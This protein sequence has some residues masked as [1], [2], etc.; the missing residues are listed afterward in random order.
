VRGTIIEHQ[1][2]RGRKT[3]GYSLFL[4]RDGNGKQLRQVKRGFQREKD[5]QDA[6]R[7]AIEELE[8]TPTARAMPTF[9][10]FFG[11]WHREIAVR[12]YERKTSERYEELA[13]YAIRLYGDVPLDRLTTE[14][15]AADQS[16]MLD[17][18]GCVTKQ[19]PN[20]RPLAPKT[21]RHISFLVQACL[22]Q[23]VDWDIIPKNPMVKVKKPKVPKRRPKVVDSSGFARLVNESRGL[24]IFPVIVLGMA[25]GMRRGEML[26]L[27][28]ADLDWDRATLEVSKSLEET[29][30]GL[31][32]K[33]TKSGETRRFTIPA[34]V[35]EILREHHLEQFGHRELYGA[36]YAGRN[37]IFAKPDG[38]YYSPDKMGTRIRRAML[39]A[40]L[41]GVSLHSLRHSHASEL[42]SKGVPITAVSERL[43]HASPNVTLAIYSHAMPKDDRLAAE[44]WSKAMGDA[45]KPQPK[46]GG[47]SLV[48]TEGAKK[49]AIPEESAS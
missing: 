40:G 7:K 1:P 30:A 39:K 3:F 4:G 26:A 13:Q 22:Q 28:W 48:I 17:H 14:Q 6:L 32:I 21:V 16:R 11:R 41:S 20:G 18:G 44:V 49:P 37:L 29:D 46:G 15:L 47:L 12:E 34:D 43:G 23:A 33:G 10:E 19:H 5:A 38:E 45:L 2:K 31:R 27:E 9:A 42:L 24:A 25:T 8:H 35:L 36:D